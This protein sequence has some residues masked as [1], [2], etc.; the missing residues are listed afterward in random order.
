MGLFTWDNRYSVSTGDET[1]AEAR[2]INA[3]VAYMET[4]DTCGLC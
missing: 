2:S 4:I 1:G 3:R